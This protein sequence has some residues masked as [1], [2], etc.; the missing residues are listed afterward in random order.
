M[1]LR[2]LHYCAACCSKPA[3][4]AGDIEFANGTAFGASLRDI[5]EGPEMSIQLL[6]I[7]LIAERTQ[8]IAIQCVFNLQ[9]SLISAIED[10]ADIEKLFS[11]HPRHNPDNGI[12]K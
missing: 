9:E 2:R 12:F 5:L 3:E 4:P 7:R 1:H 10:H 8:P 11:F 6:S